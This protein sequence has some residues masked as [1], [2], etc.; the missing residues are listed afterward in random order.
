MPAT[1]RH[2]KQA[3]QT[4]GHEWKDDPAYDDPHDSIDL[5][6]LELWIGV[7]RLMNKVCEKSKRELKA[8]PV[9]LKKPPAKPVIKKNTR[10]AA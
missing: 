8:K 5:E 10:R 4:Q 3:R 6:V 7:S 9:K 2:A 1:R